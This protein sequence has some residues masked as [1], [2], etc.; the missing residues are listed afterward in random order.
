MVWGVGGVKINCTLRIIQTGDGNGDVW[1]PTP[2]PRWHCLRLM[3]EARAAL[4]MSVRRG[5]VQGRDPADADLS[6][7]HSNEQE[8]TMVGMAAAQLGTANPLPGFFTAADC[9]CFHE[10][11][12]PHMNVL[13]PRHSLRP[14][15][16]CHR[17]ACHAALAQLTKRGCRSPQLTAQTK[18]SQAAH[19][20]MR[21][22]RGPRE[23]ATCGPW[24]N[25]NRDVAQPPCAQ[26][27]C[28][29]PRMGS[30]VVCTRL[31]QK[32]ANADDCPLLESNQ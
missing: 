29:S 28:R 6:V 20:T 17:P 24:P 26:Q 21:L 14:T 8:A 18:S 7:I 15:F 12:R 3:L 23:E 27:C 9:V 32:D 2:T 22:E 11:S 13:P 19:H 10:S 5:S 31:Q 16:G 30:E 25:P 4:G 1:N